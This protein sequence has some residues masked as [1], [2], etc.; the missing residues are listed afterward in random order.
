MVLY[1]SMV[2]GMGRFQ[3]SSPG[4]NFR[5][6]VV[7]CHTIS[8]FMSNACDDLLASSFLLLGLFGQLL[9]FTP[10]IYNEELKFGN[11]DNGLITN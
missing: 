5:L 10:R 3:V 2:M 9:R 8:I 4:Q 6:Y 1:R 11:V 7:C